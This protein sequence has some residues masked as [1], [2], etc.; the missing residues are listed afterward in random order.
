VLCAMQ[1]GGLNSRKGADE[2]VAGEQQHA[3]QADDGYSADQF[4]ALGESTVS[5]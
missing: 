1:A 2:E 4:T 5:M 3:P